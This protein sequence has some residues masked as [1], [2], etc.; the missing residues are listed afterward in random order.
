MN[1]APQLPPQVDGSIISIT[2]HCLETHQ[3]VVLVART[4]FQQPSNPL[5]TGCIPPLCIPGVVDEI[6]FE[7]HCVRAANGAP[8]AK[9]EKFVNGSAEYRLEMREHISLHESKMVELSEASEAHINELDFSNF[10]PGS[11]IAFR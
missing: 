8:F 4:A 1:L 9:H 6:V 5:E 10:P 11:V 3:S 2:R 7:A